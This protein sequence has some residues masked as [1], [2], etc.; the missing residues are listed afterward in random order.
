[1]RY[2]TCISIQDGYYVRCA[3]GPT[4]VSDLAWQ[5]VIE[6]A[7]FLETVELARALVSSVPAITHRAYAHVAAHVHATDRRLRPSLQMCIGPFRLTPQVALARSQ[8]PA[9]ALQR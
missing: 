1:M 2:D 6:I 4:C 3:G 5:P 7:L 8:P 9:P